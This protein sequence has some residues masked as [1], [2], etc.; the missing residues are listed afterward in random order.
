MFLSLQSSESGEFDRMSSLDRQ[1]SEDR[2]SSP[3]NLQPYSSKFKTMASLK[4]RS[5]QSHRGISPP[6]S[7]ERDDNSQVLIIKQINFD[8]REDLPSM[9]EISLSFR[10]KTTDGFNLFSTVNLTN[11]ENISAEEMIHERLS[12]KRESMVY[13]Q[14]AEGDEGL[15][16]DPEN[17][18]L[19]GV[20]IEMMS[21]DDESKDKKA[22][23]CFRKKHTLDQGIVTPTNHAKGGSSSL[24]QAN[25]GPYRT[26]NQDSVGA[27]SFGQNTLIKLLD[28]CIDEVGSYNQNQTVEGSTSKNLKENIDTLIDHEKMLHDDEELS[29]FV[30]ELNS[31]IEKRKSIDKRNGIDRRRVETDTILPGI[32]R[33]TKTATNL[34]PHYSAKVIPYI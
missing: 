18:S 15:M 11:R 7:P 26:A 20:S 6:S 5:E 1:C 13:T 31:S 17:E 28:K 30:E 29:K 23:I 34:S 16:L 14:A 32:I 8:S 9:P 12:R 10:K 21:A 2:S 25:I 4:T 24:K 19:L 27:Q 22:R 33:S 3:Q